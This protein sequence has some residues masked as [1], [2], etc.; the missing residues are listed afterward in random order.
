MENSSKCNIP[1]IIFMFKI[2]N[3]DNWNNQYFIIPLKVAYRV[4][5]LDSK[6]NNNNIFNKYSYFKGCKSD[7]S[8]RYDIDSHTQRYNICR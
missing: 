5:F 1:V 7:G 3:T 8:S 2:S 6:E 4:Y